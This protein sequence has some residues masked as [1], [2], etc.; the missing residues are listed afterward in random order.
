VATEGKFKGMKVQLGKFHTE[1]DAYVL[2][3]GNL[4]M[5]WV[6]LGYNGLEK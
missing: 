6:W 4:D 1:V 3:L 2:E 5:I